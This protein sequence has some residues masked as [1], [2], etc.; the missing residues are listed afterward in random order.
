MPL[1]KELHLKYKI[2]RETWATEALYEKLWFPKTIFFFLFN[3]QKLP[4]C[5][6]IT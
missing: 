3:Y 6:E 4:R 5:M 2:T 1:E